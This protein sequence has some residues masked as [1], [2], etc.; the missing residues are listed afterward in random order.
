MR[1]L[2]PVEAALA[3]ALGGSCLAVSIPAFVRNLHASRIAE[4]LDAL[5]RLSARA[6][7]LAEFSPQRSAY[8]ESV[9]LTPAKVPRGE[10]VTDPPGT[11]DHPSWRILDFAITTPHAYSFEFTSKNAEEASTFDAQAHGDLDG[12]GVL[13][14]LEVSGEIKPGRKATLFPLEVVREVE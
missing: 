14:T 5:Q 12:D 9:P 3:F 13:S 7:A 4:P 11:W 8:P 1:P 10:L 6:Q 2:T